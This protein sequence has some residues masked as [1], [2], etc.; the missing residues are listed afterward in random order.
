MA[1]TML[2]SQTC[3]KKRQRRFQCLQLNPKNKKRQESH[4]LKKNLPKGR[5]KRAERESPQD[6]R[7]RNKRRRHKL[8]KSPLTSQCRFKFKQFLK[9]HNLEFL[10]SKLSHLPKIH[11]I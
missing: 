3:N 9:C 10:I 1:P 2:L 4:P 7:L 11:S 6:Q 5:E 8:K